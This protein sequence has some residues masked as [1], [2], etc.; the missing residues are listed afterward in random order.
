[1]R[2]IVIPSREKLNAG[3]PETGKFST[4][5]VSD[6]SGSCPAAVAAFRDASRP[7]LLASTEGA[8]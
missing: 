2:F 6:G 1:M 3:G 5:T 7:A 8:F 4:P